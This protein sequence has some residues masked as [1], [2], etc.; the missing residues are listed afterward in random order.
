M[1]L[2][3][4]GYGIEADGR[5]V[6]ESSIFLLPAATPASVAVV[7]RCLTADLHA[8][9][10]FE[11]A[12]ADAVL[13][14]SELLSNAICHAQSLPGS[15]LQVT[16]AV[17]DES[18]EVA[19][20]DG[21]SPTRPRPAPASLSAQRGRGLGIVDNLSRTWGVRADDLGITV[22]AIV[23]A[24]TRSKIGSVCLPTVSCR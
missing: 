21:G 8:V 2:F 24:P 14:T 7:R 10:I 22:W 11:T 16:W 3:V 12:I 13:V 15:R 4:G 5:G 18:V 9:G 6:R 17:A 20:S 19:V 23:P 1:V